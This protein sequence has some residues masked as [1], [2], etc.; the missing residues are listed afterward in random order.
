MIIANLAT[1]PPRAEFLP[2]VVDA[3][4]PQVDQLNIVLNEYDS[5]PEFLSGYK[6]VNALV[7]DHD[8]KDAG[9][10]LFDCTQAEYVVLIDDDLV[11]PKDYVAKSVARMRAL[12][13]G[14]YLGG[15]HCSIYN[16]PGL[17]P[18]SIKSVKANIRFLVSPSH[19]ARFRRILFLG[20]G[21]TDPVVVDQIGSGTAIIR[22][23]DIPPYEFMKPSQKF[24][25][26]R[27][28]RWCFE[29]G[30]VRVSL[31][32]ENGWLCQCDSKGV[33]V[34][35]T[36]HDDFTQKHHKHVAQEIRSFAFKDKRVGRPCSE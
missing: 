12:G 29:Q 14:R 28:A 35:E 30:I 16:R 17:R 25:D 20:H 27:L 8:T 10:F 5:V 7:P 31:P 33:I 13:P 15:Y 9:K 26:V 23:A 18:I 11:Y 24:V 3:I 2:S 19:I 32:R 22:G 4:S 34:E 21:L 6:N 1:Y 36:I